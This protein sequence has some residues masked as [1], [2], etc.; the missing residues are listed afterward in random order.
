MTKQTPNGGTYEGGRM[1]RPIMDERGFPD[2]TIDELFAFDSARFKTSDQGVRAL[3]L[4]RTSKLHAYSLRNNL[5]VSADRTDAMRKLREI[6]AL[7]LEAIRLEDV[8]R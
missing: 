6:F 5:V 3:E 7:A 2:E 4:Q 1:P 8:R